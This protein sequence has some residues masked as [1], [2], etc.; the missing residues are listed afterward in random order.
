MSARK[1]LD[2]NCD[3]S[4]F[5]PVQGHVAKRWMPFQQKEHWAHIPL[6]VGQEKT[7][8]ERKAAIRSGSEEGR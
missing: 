8:R 1:P 3:G 6:T 7:R 2:P 4:I 5:C